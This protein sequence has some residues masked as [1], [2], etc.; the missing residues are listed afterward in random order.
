MSRRLPS[1]RRRRQMTLDW[2]ALDLRGG[3]LASLEA[4]LRAEGFV[5]A[6][7]VKAW[8]RNDGTMTVRLVW[9]CRSAEGC[10]TYTVVYRGIRRVA[11]EEAAAA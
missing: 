2:S 4:T 6:E 11:H 7:R 3:F 9:R 10:N 8:C 1:R 5:R